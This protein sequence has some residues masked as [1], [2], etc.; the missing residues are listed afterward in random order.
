MR[1]LSYPRGATPREWGRIH[2]ESFR[3]EIGS[4]AELRWYLTGRVGGIARADAERLATMHLPV[5][6]RYDDA[7]YQELCGIAEG[8][9][10]RPEDVVVLNHYTDLRDIDP[11][12]PDGPPADGGSH[13]GGGEGCSVFFTAAPSGG[14][15]VAQT[16]DMH[17]TAMPY[18]MML[19]VPDGDGPAA[20]LLS[21]TGCLGMA[22]L[23]GAGVAVAINNLTSTDARVGLVWPALVRRVLREASAGA[24]RDLVLAAP[25]GSG[26]H[27]LVA[28]A[29]TAYGIEAS[30]TRRAV[31]FD[32]GAPLYVHTNH[33]LD[34]E[35]AACSRIPPGSTTHER[36]D[37]LRAD[38]EARP[39]R[40]LS[41]AM[42]RLGSHDGYPRSV[43]ANLATPEQPHL[44]ATCAAVAISPV[45]RTLVA[46]AGFPHNVEPDQ[47]WTDRQ[48]NAQSG[49]IGSAR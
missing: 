39:V 8:A 21:L 48:P 26:H 6:E 16:W 17:A 3:G 5:L 27:Y 42:R 9:A 37:R 25:L 11:R 43:C 33:C 2:G 1:R 10:L 7:L 36:F 32:G 30:G 49:E 40:D 23:N 18:V 34:R 4:L 24:A 44:M 20:M 35:V 41:D 45:A 14:P 28:D 46:V 13:D 29:T 38:L 47:Y 19:E 22:G 15:I 31:V 12:H